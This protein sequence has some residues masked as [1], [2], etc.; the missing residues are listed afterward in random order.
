MTTL[1]PTP[2][3][4]AVQEYYGKLAREAGSFCEASANSEA[5]ACC[6]TSAKTEEIHNGL[7]PVELLNGIPADIANASAGSG[8]PI[9]LANLQPGETVL[10]LGS[11]AGLDCFL[12]AK[13]VGA[14]GH[15]IGVDMTPEM[16][17]RARANATRLNAR[18]IEFREGFL[19]ALPLDD[20]GI[21]VII[22]NCVIN[23][24]PDKP[25]VFREMY[26][27]LKPGG[28]IALSDM[29]ANHPL[30]D[31]ARKNKEGWCGCTSGALQRQEYEK[32][33]RSVGFTE[34]R[35]E[36]NVDAVVSAFESGQ[37]RLPE[38]FTKEQMLADLHSW[39]KSARTMIVPHKI[40]ARKQA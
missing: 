10:D 27:A 37:V 11:G 8:D 29:V 25:R 19:E 14:S 2:T 32:Q 26:R 13:Q 3:H 33:L 22:S 17:E 18:N 35:M 15:V 38:N 16:L 23:L 5:S 20:G 36:P 4:Q 9:S 21:D 6:G 40:T 1:T 28:R 34:I 12:A 24:S 7:Y 30:S 31:E 39:E